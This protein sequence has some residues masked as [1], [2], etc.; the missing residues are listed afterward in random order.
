MISFKN[1]KENSLGIPLPKG[2][3]RVFKE[4]LE[5]GSL[6]F[7][8]ED[9]IDHTPKDELI[10]LGTGT[11]FDIVS[12]KVSSSK[13]SNKDGS[14]SANLTLTISNKKDIAAEVVV[15]FNNYYGDNLK[16]LMA[17]ETKLNKISSNE[18]RWSKILQA[19][20]VWNVSWL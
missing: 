11:A 4:D 7:I 13:T 14:Y 9:N 18:Y 16:I 8:G 2:I 20:E 1:S 15:K 17:G 3:V 5:D 19:N 10:K 6:E 12:N